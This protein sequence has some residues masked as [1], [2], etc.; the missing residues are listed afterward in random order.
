L[1]AVA[2]MWNGLTF[3]DVQRVFQEWMERLTWVVGNNGE[4]YP[5]YR[6]QFRKWSIVQWNRPGGQ[7]FLDTLYFIF[8]PRE[9][10]WTGSTCHNL[11]FLLSMRTMH[12]H[13]PKPPHIFNRAD[14]APFPTYLSWIAELLHI[15]SADLMLSS[16]IPQEIALHYSSIWIQTENFW[17]S[18]P[19][20]R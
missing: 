12:I 2:K 15:F 1:S 17:Q 13:S 8:L 4:Y 20:I 11:C 14:K 19:S 10:R 18:R 7:D 9:P 6:H 5:N 16:R 3:A